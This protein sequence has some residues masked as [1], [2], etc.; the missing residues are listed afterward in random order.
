MDYIDIYSELTD[1]NV[2]LIR[3]NMSGRF[4]GSVSP[5]RRI[6]LHQVEFFAFFSI[7]IFMLSIIQVLVIVF[8]TRANTPGA[9]GFA[10]TY[11]FIPEGWSM[12]QN[13]KLNTENKM[14]FI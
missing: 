13:V 14:L 3:F 6:S 1:H 9:P 2:D 7:T 11:E 8:H 10:G 5:K 4:C 12:Y